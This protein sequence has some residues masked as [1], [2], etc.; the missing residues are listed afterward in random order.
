LH[1]EFILGNDDW[2]V[3]SIIG[4]YFVI[5]LGHATANQAAPSDRERQQ[6]LAPIRQASHRTTAFLSGCSATPDRD[7]TRRLERA[8]QRG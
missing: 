7:G 5:G 3:R 2:L 1:K 6:A 4:L 8:R